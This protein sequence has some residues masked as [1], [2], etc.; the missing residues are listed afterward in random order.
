MNL[1]YV[2]EDQ[3]RATLARHGLRL[4]ERHVFRSTPNEAG[5]YQ[6]ARELSALQNR[7]TAIVLINEAIAVGLYRGLVEAGVKPGRDL[8]IIG[9]Q[10]PQSEFLSPR[11]TSFS[12]SLRDLGI[13][14]AET[15]LGTMPAFAHVYPAKPAQLLW[16]MALVPGESD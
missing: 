7:P 13:A 4:D 5:G 10:S 8:A 1:G 9:R 6:I 16:P 14:L 15:L 3:C 2:F 12:L 11:L